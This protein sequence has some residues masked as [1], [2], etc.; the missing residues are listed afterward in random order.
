M[1]KHAASQA[2]ALSATVVLSCFHSQVIMNPA[3]LDSCA[4]SRLRIDVNSLLI[5]IQKAAGILEGA[6]VGEIISV[7]AS[8]HV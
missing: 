6:A 3:R 7:P 5:K 4:S 2:G 8:F 1:A